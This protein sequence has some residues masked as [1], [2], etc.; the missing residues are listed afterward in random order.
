M[1]ARLPTSW[2]ENGTFA[3]AKVEEV[4]FNRKRAEVC[5]KEVLAAEVSLIAA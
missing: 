3:T 2:Q 4:A 5:F 1:S